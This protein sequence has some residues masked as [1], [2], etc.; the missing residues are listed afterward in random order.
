MSFLSPFLLAG[1]GAIAV[2]VLVHEIKPEEMK[3]PIRNKR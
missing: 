1:L 3:V 2:P